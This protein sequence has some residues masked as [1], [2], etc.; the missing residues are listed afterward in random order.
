VCSA[1][2]LR[3]LLT[4]K[5]GKEVRVIRDVRDLLFTIDRSVR[6]SKVPNL[7]GLVLVELHADVNVDDLLERF[8]KYPIPGVFRVVPFERECRLQ[9]DEISQCVISLL[10][11][12][13]RDLPHF[14]FAVRCTF[15]KVGGDFR[16]EDVEREIGARVL[17]HFRN[18]AKV[19]LSNPMY[20]I[21]IESIGEQVGIFVERRKVSDNERQ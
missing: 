20:V 18:K 2:I 12:K 13:T 1:K 21:Y 14:T 15:R 4:T 10:E 3:V 7:A 17:Q 11:E 9:V 19:N 5:P 8:R 16:E 6:A